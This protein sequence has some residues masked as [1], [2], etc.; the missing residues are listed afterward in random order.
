MVSQFF[1]DAKNSYYVS[2]QDLRWKVAMG[3][4]EFMSLRKTYN[5]L[6]Q[7]KELPKHNYTFRVDTA[8]LQG[9]IE[10]L[11]E[12]LNMK[13]GMTIRKSLLEHKFKNLFLYER[14]GIRVKKLFE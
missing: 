2:S 11:S 14:G 5:V 4:D 3:S 8:K 10:F 13:P 9:V 12:T 1:E 6:T 7:G